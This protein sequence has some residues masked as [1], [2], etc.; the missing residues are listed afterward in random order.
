[1]LRSSWIAAAL[2]CLSGCVSTTEPSD[3]PATCPRPQAPDDRLMAAPPEFQPM[4]FGVT[5]AEALVIETANNKACRLIRE[6]HVGLQHH[7]REVI[8]K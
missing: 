2:C 4:T 8:L 1:M 7:V 6:R 5:E 3:Y